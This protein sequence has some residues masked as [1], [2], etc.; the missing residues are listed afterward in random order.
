MKSTSRQKFLDKQKARK[1]EYINNKRKE[2]Q[3]KQIKEYP[4]NKECEL[5]EFLLNTLKDQSRNN[6]KSLLTHRLVSIDGIT[7]TQYNYKL[8]KGDVVQ[9]SKTPLSAVKDKRVRNNLSNII[10]EDD[11]IIVINKP[12][13]LLAI[14]TD[15]EKTRTAYKQL[16]E[17]VQHQNIH[18]RVFVV[19]RIDKDTSGVLMVAKNENLKN[20]LQDKW[21]DLVS[22]RKY[23]AICEGIFDKKQGTIKQYL[24]ENKNNIM[25]NSHN[26]N[27]GQEATTHYKVLKESTRYSLVEVFIDSGRKNQIRVALNDLGHPIVGDTKYGNASDPLGRLGLHAE[28]LELKHPIT[29]NELKFKA[30]IPSEFNKLFGGK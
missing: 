23:I 26:A 15:K 4:V 30:P 7:T 20:K 22:T 27:D 5:L 12:S 8:Y 18:N 16:T 28:I 17:Y 11:E 1:Q 10:Y 19:H 25:Y 24:K 13:G 21:N 2:Y 6:V 14:A 9:I 3:V 29:G